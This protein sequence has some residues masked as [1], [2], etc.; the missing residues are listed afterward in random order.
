MRKVEKFISKISEDL[1]IKPRKIV[2]DASFRSFYRFNK[3]GKKFILIFCTKN[4]KS[5]LYNY[6][7]I[8]KILIKAHILQNIYIKNRFWIKKKSYSMD[9]EDL[10]IVDY[11]KDK[12]MGF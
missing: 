2:G 5:N 11:F 12:E 4:K 9:N 6:I 10:K 3:K 7:K 8:N 1:K